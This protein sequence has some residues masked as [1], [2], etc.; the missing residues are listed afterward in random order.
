MVHN[1]ADLYELSI[2]QL[3]ELE[4]MGEKSA[5]KIIRNIDHSRSQ[6]LARVLNGLGIPFVGERT[7]QILASHFGSVDE[8]AAASAETLQ[9]ANEIGP[10]VADAIRQFFAEER[11]RELIERL[12]AAGLTL[13]RPE[14]QVNERGPLTGTDFRA[15]R[16][17]ADTETRRGEGSASKSQAARWRDRSAQDKLSGGG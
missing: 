14:G 8:I 13:H 11:N 1:I 12:R 7:A 5:S 2:D 10:K 6:P 16:H 15:H 17:V 3:L 9:E 4:R